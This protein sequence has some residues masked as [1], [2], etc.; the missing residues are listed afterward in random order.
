MIVDSLTLLWNAMA[1][2]EVIVKDVVRQRLHRSVTQ[3]V[4]RHTRCG[5]LTESVRCASCERAVEEAAS[6]VHHVHDHVC[7]DYGTSTRA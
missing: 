5:R 7:E 4:A 2:V 1:K 3:R 6:L